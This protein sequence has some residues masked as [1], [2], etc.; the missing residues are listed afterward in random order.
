MN[1]T[2]NSTS[3]PPFYYCA[4]KVKSV[5]IFTIW[6][7]VYLLFLPLFLFVL[8]IG[9]RKWQKQRCLTTGNISHSDV[10]TFHMVAMEMTSM[11]GAC[12]VC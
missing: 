6:F 11:V 3:E 1:T 10:F 9:F 4:Y 12:V 7:I 2:A 8:Y 5:I